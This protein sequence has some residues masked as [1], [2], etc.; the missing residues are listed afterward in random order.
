M[1]TWVTPEISELNLSCTEQGKDMS[2]SWDEIRVD[3]NGEF[4]VS[5]QSG[6]DSNPK[7]VGP[8]I[9]H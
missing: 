5:F 4:W 6:G 2:Q 7:P 9:V 8:I 3:Q 1:K